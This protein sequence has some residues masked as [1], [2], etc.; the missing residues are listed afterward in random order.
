MLVPGSAFAHR[1][2]LLSV[3]AVLP[4]LYIPTAAEAQAATPLDSWNEGAAK[5]AIFY[6]VK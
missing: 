3:L 6:F 2:F 1:R 5:Q 4:A